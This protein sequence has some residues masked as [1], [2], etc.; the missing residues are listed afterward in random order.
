LDKEHPEEDPMAK[1]GSVK[2]PAVVRVQ[3]EERAQEITH[4]CHEHGWRFIVGIEPDKPENMED[5]KWLQ[6]H[7]AA[8]PK[9]Y[10]GPMKTGPNDYC[11]CGSGL[12]HKNCCMSK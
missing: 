7:R 9:I 4:L 11:P 10:S 12:K 2:K 1:L 5:I 3:T 6:K 8:K